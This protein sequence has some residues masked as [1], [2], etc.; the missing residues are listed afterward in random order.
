MSIVIRRAYEPAQAA[1]GY[2]VLVDRLWPR[3]VSKS[4]LKLDL[5]M[6]DVS[7]S[8]ELRRWFAH[9]VARWVQFQKR[10]VAELKQKPELIQDLRQRGRRGRVTLVYGTRD[11]VHNSA[12]VLKKYLDG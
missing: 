11:E 6:K 10:Y 7:P 4:A 12:A 5:W 3:G 1:D 8:P 9:D 2:R